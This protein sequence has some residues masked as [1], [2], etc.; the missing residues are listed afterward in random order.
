MSG[1][2]CSVRVPLKATLK[3]IGLF[4]ENSTFTDG[5]FYAKGLFII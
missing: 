1:S 5:K 3:Q 2:I 4:A